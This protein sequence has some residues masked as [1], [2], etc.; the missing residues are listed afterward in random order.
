MKF[1]IFSALLG[2][3][4]SA[5]AQS[6]VS[7]PTTFINSEATNRYVLPIDKVSV[8]GSYPLGVSNVKTVHVIFPAEIKEV[9][10]GTADILVQI[11]PSFNNVLKVKSTVK[12]SFPETNLTVLTADGGLYSFLITYQ[13]NPEILNVNIG[14]NL[15]SDVRESEALAI[16][17]FSKTEYLDS[18]LNES[19]VVID[20]NLQRIVN[21]RPFIRNVGVESLNVRSLLRGIYASDDML[22]FGFSIENNTGIDYQIDFVKLY[23]KDKEQAKKMTSQEEELPVIRRFPVDDEITAKSE[24]IFAIATPIRTIADNKV[25]EIEIYDKTGGRHLRYQIDPKILAKAKKINR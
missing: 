25:M 6:G 23:V 16:N 12:E 10:A 11:T 8:K 5:L 20:N 4:I 24:R 17:Y 2:V 1:I 3:P 19:Y 21:N 15:G 14:K 13:K 9:D 22:Y 18:E 7:N